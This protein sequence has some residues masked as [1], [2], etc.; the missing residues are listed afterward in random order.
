MSSVSQLKVWHNTNDAMPPQLVE[1]RTLS[2]G[3]ILAGGFCKY[4]TVIDRWLDQESAWLLG[5]LA[6]LSLEQVIVDICRCG[7]CVPLR[8]LPNIFQIPSASLG[9][10]RPSKRILIHRIERTLSSFPSRV[11]G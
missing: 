4:E 3:E 9:F 1:K 2:V 6:I 11:R 8:I 5:M 10:T 7:I